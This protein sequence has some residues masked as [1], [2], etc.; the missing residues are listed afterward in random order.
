M[1]GRIVYTPPT[2]TLCELD[3]CADKPEAKDFA[4]GTIWECDHCGR[5]WIVW[6]GAQYNEQFSAWRRARVEEV[7]RMKVATIR[8]PE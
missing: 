5:H 7:A 4:D 1:T 3:M 2:P 6:S 8:G